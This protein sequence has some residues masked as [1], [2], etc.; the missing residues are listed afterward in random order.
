MHV[1]IVEEVEACLP[2]PCSS[3]RGRR[4]RYRR[5]FSHHLFGD[6]RASAIAELA[7]AAGA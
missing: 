6:A 2:P 7:R 1:T 3:Y 5:N 4:R